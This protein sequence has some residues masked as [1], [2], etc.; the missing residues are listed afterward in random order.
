M[1]ELLDAFG[2]A[3][4]E[5]VA[6]VFLKS[7][8]EFQQYLEQNKTNP[9]LISLKKES[10]RL[11]SALGT[12]TEDEAAGCCEK[13]EHAPSVEV[14]EAEIQN[15]LTLAPQV[16]LHIQSFLDEHRNDPL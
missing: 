16:H 3:G 4:L 9:N 5:E 10:H 1:N 8:T 14:A 2:F 7:L 15:F 12:F 13:M 6:L 11:K